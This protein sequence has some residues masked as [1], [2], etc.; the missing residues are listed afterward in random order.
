MAGPTRWSRVELAALAGG[1][2]IYLALTCWQLDLP[3]PHYDEA[4]EVLPA[5]QLLLGQPVESFRGAGLQIGPLHL[6]IMVMDY[7]G[8]I[9]TYLALPFF[10]VAG[11]NVVAMRLMPIFFGAGT[12]LLTYFFARET[13]GRPAALVALFALAG[14][15]SFVFWSRQG[16]FVTNLTS[17]IMMGMLLSGLC[18]WRAGRRR[19]LYLTLFLA[20]MGLYTKFLF[21]WAILGTA[22]AL[23]LVNVDRLARALRRRQG[24]LWPARLQL[25]RAGR[26]GA[27][28][29]F[30]LPLSPLI[31]FNLQTGGT[32]A[33]LTGNLSRSYYGVNNLA[34]LPNLAQRVQQFG[35]VL[36]GDHFWYLGEVFANRLWAPAFLTSLAAALAA[37]L[38]R[39]RA[40]GEDWRAALFPYAAIAL[41]IVQ[42]CF[43]ISALWF[44]HFALL[45]PLPALALAGGLSFAARA[46]GRPRVLWPA[47][48]VLVAGVVGSDLL[49]GV[50][51]HDVLARSGGYDA[52]SDASYRL[53]QALEEEAAGP[54]VALDWGIQAQVQFLTHGR[55]APREAFGY[56]D[57]A[58]PDASFAER[59]RPY[60]S[61]PRTIYV[62]HAPEQEVYRGRAPAFSALVEATGRHSR[63]LR[64][65]YERSGRPAYVLVKVD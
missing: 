37:S 1:L 17:T 58:A 10:L 62:F 54:V 16:I 49:T 52:H 39:R 9:N 30:L 59:L 13:L 38:W 65:I 53:A 50:R 43:T 46:S 60:L 28:L 8:A 40:V 11:I 5:M 7:I 63:I 44:T 51:Y 2:A 20:G 14:G 21:L 15:V 27:L 55:V 12:L 41:I 56:A 6:P 42:S 61:D 23:A 64:V 33:T 18:W 19:R 24:P 45:T 3:G 31:L 57:L 36:R 4:I 47:I 35:S 34:F 48:I 26:L 29:A 32:L 22:G 25:D